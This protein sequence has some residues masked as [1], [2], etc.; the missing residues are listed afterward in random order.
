MPAMK[1]K[2]LGTVSFLGFAA[3]A[4][5]ASAQA[6]EDDFWISGSGFFA[7]VDTKVRSSLTTNPDGGTEIDL[8]EDLGLDDNELLPAIYVGAKLGGGFVITAEYYSL[9]RDTTAT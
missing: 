6:I 5:P 9:S 8:E 4:A 3:L 2:I 1:L 7:N